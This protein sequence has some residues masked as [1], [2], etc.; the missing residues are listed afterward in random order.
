M[1]YSWGWY[2]AYLKQTYPSLEW[3]VAPLPTWTGNLAPAYERNNGDATPGVNP[4][5]S[6]DRK[7]VAFDFI[8]FLLDNEQATIDTVLMTAQGPVMKRIVD[9]PELQA[10]KITSLAASLLDRTVWPGA[11]PPLDDIWTKTIIDG[12]KTQQSVDVILKAYEEQSNAGIAELKSI[13]WIYERSYAHNSD[14]RPSQ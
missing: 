7:A 12:L 9:R 4:K 2:G 1:T 3:D 10:S 14:M 6:D 11:L 8:H 5:I 13:F